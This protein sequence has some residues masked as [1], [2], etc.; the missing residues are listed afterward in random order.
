MVDCIPTA[1]LSGMALTAFCDLTVGK[2][3][4]VSNELPKEPICSLFSQSWW[5]PKG[6]DVIRRVV[7]LSQ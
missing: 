4:Q 7:T 6:K 1:L 3:A 5:K 2:L